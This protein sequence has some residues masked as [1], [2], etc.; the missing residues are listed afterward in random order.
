[1]QGKTIRA[2]ESATHKPHGGFWKK[3]KTSIRHH[4]RPDKIS[5]DDFFPL[6]EEIEVVEKRQDDFFPL[7]YYDDDD[8]QQSNKEDSA[9]DE[10]DIAFTAEN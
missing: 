1:M 4:V 10:E 3:P 5:R 9:E 7:E 6:E 2:G 8:N